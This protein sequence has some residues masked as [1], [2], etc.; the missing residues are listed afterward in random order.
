MDRRGKPDE[1]EL[2]WRDRVHDLKNPLSAILANCQYL[3]AHGALSAAD[4]DVMSDITASARTLRRMLDDAA[5]PLQ[6]EEPQSLML[7][8]SAAGR[9]K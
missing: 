3:M 6:P 8:N 7:G 5:R 4:R 1:V 9:A 2:A